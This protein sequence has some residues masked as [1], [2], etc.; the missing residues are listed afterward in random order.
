MAGQLTEK[1]QQILDY[2]KSEILRKAIRLRCVRYVS[3]F[4]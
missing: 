3:L 2:I 4:I 1:Q